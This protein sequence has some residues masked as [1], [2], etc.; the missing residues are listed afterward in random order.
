MVEVKAM[1]IGELARRVGVP[2]SALRYYES[3]GVL[4][5]PRRVS[6]RREYGA[7]AVDAVELLRAAQAAGF[8]L[9][10]ARALLSS[11]AR[12]E[13]PSPAWPDVARAKLAQL[14]VTIGRLRAARAALAAAVD[15][16]CA[17]RASACSLVASTRGAVV[18]PRSKGN[19]R[20]RR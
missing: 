14:D 3:R 12:R 8:T 11:L 5:A 17:G 1:R 20:P 19:R 7:D 18:K 15:C 9:A 6:G 16:A 4:P 13:R 2:A 10:E